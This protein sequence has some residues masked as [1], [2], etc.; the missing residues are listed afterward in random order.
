MR[1]GMIVGEF[2]PVS[3]GAGHYVYHLSRSLREMGFE[4]EVFTRSDE[5]E[6]HENVEGIEVHRLPCP[7][8]YPF[9]VDLH[10]IH[11]KKMVKKREKDID[12]FHL[13]SPLI[14]N[15]KIK[16]P[17]VL[18]EHGTSIGFISN[19]EGLS[20]KEKMHKLLGGHFI[21]IDKKLLRRYDN[22]VAVSKFTREEIIEEY[23]IKNKDIKVFYN[24]VDEDHYIPTYNDEGFIL[25]TGEL[26]YKKG[27]Q[28][29]IEAVNII[30]NK[31][32]L[33]FD[34]HL[35]SKG[36]LMSYLK[37]KIKEYKLEDRV[38]LHGFV[39]TEEL[40]NLYQNCTAYVLPSYYEGFP[41]TI[42]EAM[43]CGKPFITT[44][45]PGCNELIKFNDNNY[46]YE[47]GNI[48][49]LVKCLEDLIKIK[50]DDPE[51]LERTGKQ[52]RMLIE[53]KFN[54]RSISK[55]YA[56]FYEISLNR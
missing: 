34:F 17:C 8:L 36:P 41:T 46:E 37:G 1:I 51:R 40:K 50:M 3:G 54:W 5:K 6:S 2:P 13:H 33:N 9:H 49:Q 31:K 15:I 39:K 42:L 48:E 11:L 18:T 4:V 55:L 56:E 44:D 20:F 22:I 27:S 12:L 14:P 16:K 32:G 23:K 24:G 45:A 35:T 30:I 53:N 38:K 43:A 25:Y 29:L 28:D 47:V 21:R 19:L 26:T 10:G 7:K 52:N